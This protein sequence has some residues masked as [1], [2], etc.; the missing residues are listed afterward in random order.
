MCPIIV[1]SENE[2]K[3]LVQE[4]FEQITERISF[5]KKWCQN[6]LTFKSYLSH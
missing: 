5:A 6:S 3:D 2:F 1:E 4:T